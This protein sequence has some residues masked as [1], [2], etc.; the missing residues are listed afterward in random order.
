LMHKIQELVTSVTYPNG[1]KWRKFVNENSQLART[2]LQ[3]FQLNFFLLQIWFK[4]A[5]LQRIGTSDSFQSA[6]LH[7]LLDDF[8]QQFPKADLQKMDILLEDTMDAI[9]KNLHMP[10][11]LT[12]LLIK[13]Q[14]QLA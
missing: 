4:S 5:H 7:H 8:N 6:E 3:Q 2:D 11:I 1:R 10:L 14:K 9:G 12:D 13:I